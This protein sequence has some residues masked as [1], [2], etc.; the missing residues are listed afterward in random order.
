MKKVICGFSILIIA[1]ALQGCS[2]I[3]NWIE[4]DIKRYVLGFII[5]L[6]IGVIGL[7]IFLF[8]KKDK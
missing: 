2:F 8:Q 4:F 5:T 6:A 1:L 3:G 7:V